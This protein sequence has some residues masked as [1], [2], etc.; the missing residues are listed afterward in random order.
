MKR[1]LIAIATAG[2]LALSATAFAGYKSASKV[3]VDSY[4]FSGSLGTAR[5][6]GD[7]AQ[8]IGC[9]VTTYSNNTSSMFCY[10]QSSSYQW[11]TCTTSAPNF[12]SLFNSLNGDSVLSVTFDAYGACTSMRVTNASEAEPKVR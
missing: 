11:K 8:Q 1:A 7:T 4:S 5:N 3:Y 10:A 9:R 12:I 2:T 6:S